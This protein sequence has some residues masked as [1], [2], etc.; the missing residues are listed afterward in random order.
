MVGNPGVS[1][2]GYP[3]WARVTAL[4]RASMS[5]AAF[6]VNS[7]M[8]GARPIFV[9]DGASPPAVGIGS[10]PRQQSPPPKPVNA[11]R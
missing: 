11:I 2:P 9:T 6:L 7:G 4:T 8:V 5:N 10:R 1:G 3:I